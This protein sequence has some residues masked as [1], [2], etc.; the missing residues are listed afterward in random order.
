MDS[1]WGY[2]GIVMEK[3]YTVIANTRED[4][5]TLDRFGFGNAITDNYI[6]IGADLE[7]T[8]GNSNQGVIYVYEIVDESTITL[9]HTLTNPNST[10]TSQFWGNRL[11]AYGDYIVVG[12]STGNRVHV[13]QIS[14]M[15]GSTISSAG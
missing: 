5:S 15:S 14:T 3:E 12:D 1:I 9:R 6:I 7:D 10:G 4:L 11:D 13:Y 8:S 2:G